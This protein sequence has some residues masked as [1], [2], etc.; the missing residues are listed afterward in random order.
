VSRESKDD[1][2]YIIQEGGGL[3][4]VGTYCENQEPR[5]TRP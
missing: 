2:Q 5:S 1:E 4:D 3:G